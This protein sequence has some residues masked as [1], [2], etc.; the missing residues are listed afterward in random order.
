MMNAETNAVLQQIDD[1]ISLINKTRAAVN[2]SWANSEDVKSGKVTVEDE[3]KEPSHVLYNGIIDST[4]NVLKAPATVNAL[5][6]MSKGM[7]LS[8]VGDM[9]GFI[10]LAI[11]TAAYNSITLYDGLIKDEISKQLQMFVDKINECTAEIMAHKSVLE[12]HSKRL[13]E[14]EKRLNISDIQKDINQ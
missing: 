1:I 9:L 2:E 5:T 12:V 10:A 14:I 13:T 7:E 11:S 8:A 6:S 3:Q 4:I